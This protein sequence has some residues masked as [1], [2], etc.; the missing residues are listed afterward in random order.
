MID[1]P[2]S[3]GKE[4]ERADDCNCLRALGL[5]PPRGLE[6]PLPASN[7]TPYSTRSL[8]DS[9]ERS[10]P[11]SG[12]KSGRFCDEITKADAALRQLIAL[13]PTLPVTVREQLVALAEAARGAK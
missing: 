2:D 12:S 1:E 9:A 10:T 13:W 8:G 5:P 11:E 3:P 6:P 4:K 7:V